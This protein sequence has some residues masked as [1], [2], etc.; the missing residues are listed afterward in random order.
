MGRGPA[1]PSGT[2]HAVLARMGTYL[3]LGAVGLPVEVRVPQDLQ[4]HFAYPFGHL[5]LAQEVEDFCWAVQDGRVVFS[6][7]LSPVRATE[8]KHISISDLLPAVV[9]K[10]T[11]TSWIDSPGWCFNRE[12]LRLDKRCGLWGK[13]ISLIK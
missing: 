9:I 5:L 1:H 8:V 7:F 13:L 3:C 12:G 10:G 11:K 2:Q 6:P 4:C